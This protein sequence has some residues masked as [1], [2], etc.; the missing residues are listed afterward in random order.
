MA[1]CDRHVSGHDT[2]RDKAI[3]ARPGVAA[4][5]GAA[6]GF[7]LNTEEGGRTF[8]SREREIKELA[9]RA[10]RERLRLTVR[11]THHEPHR[12]LSIIVRE[13]P[14]PFRD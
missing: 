13:P 4:A 9:E 10:W 7:S 8:R 5:F 6:L 3:A 11:V 2:G 14:T 1:A 12:S